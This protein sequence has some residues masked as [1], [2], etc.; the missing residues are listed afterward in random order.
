MQRTETDFPRVPQEISRKLY[1]LRNRSPPKTIEKDSGVTK[2]TE[3]TDLQITLITFE[4]KNLDYL[5]YFIYKTLKP[6]RF[7]FC[8]I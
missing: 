1:S 8:Y 7:C 4:K 6:L 2:I 5:I 3:V